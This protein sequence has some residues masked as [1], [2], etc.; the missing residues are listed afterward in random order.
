MDNNNFGGI[1]TVGWINNPLAKPGVKT[2][3]HLSLK[4]PRNCPVWE[5]YDL[6]ITENS[7]G[8]GVEKIIPGPYL[9]DHWF[10]TAYSMMSLHEDVPLFTT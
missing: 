8:Y 2:F 3:V 4:L 5:V 10:I 6:I 1:G 9:S 7:E